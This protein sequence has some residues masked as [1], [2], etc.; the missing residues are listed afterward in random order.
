MQ[1]A[2]FIAGMAGGARKRARLLA[3]F[4]WGL[5]GSNASRGSRARDRG[6]GEARRRADPMTPRAPQSNNWGAVRGT[7]T[8]NDGRYE[9]A[10]AL[11]E[12]YNPLP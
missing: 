1:G 3:P 12:T 4:A 6:G 11:R 7:P 2:S 8:K 10:R 5:A 9:G